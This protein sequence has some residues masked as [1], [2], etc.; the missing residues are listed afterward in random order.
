MSEKV[1]LPGKFWKYVSGQHSISLIDPNSIQGTSNFKTSSQQPSAQ[2]IVHTKYIF[3]KTSHN[4][5]RDQNKR[6]AEDTMLER[7]APSQTQGD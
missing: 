7:E 5:L 1:R 4:G 2:N 6:K 3:A